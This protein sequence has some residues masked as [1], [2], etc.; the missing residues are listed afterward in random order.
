MMNDRDL[1]Y[2]WQDHVI[3]PKRAALNLL[4]T[5]LIVAIVSAAGLRAGRDPDPSPATN[6]AATT[7]RTPSLAHLAKRPVSTHSG[8]A[9]PKGC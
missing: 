7:E 8:L 2:R 4:A 1:S 6:V 9:A 5:A 3:T